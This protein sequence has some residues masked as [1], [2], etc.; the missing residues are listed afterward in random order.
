MKEKFIITL[1]QGTTSSR[2]IVFDH[3]G[4]II[5]MASREH[6]QIYPQ[7]GWVEHDP[8]E[9]WQNQKDV[10]NEAI[11][12]GG[13]SLEEILA[14]GI[15]NQRETVVLWD[16]NTGKPVYNAIV[17]QCRRTADMCGELKKDGLEE[18][19]H[20]KTGLVIDAYFSGT[21][22]RWILDN[23]PGAR[24][25]AEKGNILAGT[26]DTWLIWKLTGGKVHATDFSN[27]SRTMLFNICDLTWD[28]DILELLQIPASILPEPKSS[29]SLFGFVG[30]SVLGR[31]IPIASAVGDQQAS[32]FGQAC[33]EPG[34][35]KNTYGTGC[36]MLAN[37]GREAVFSKNKL[38]T[39]IAWGVGNRVDYALEG[40]VFI[41]GAAIQWLRDGL[42]IIQ[43][44]RQCDELAEKV[45]DTHGVYFVPAFVGMGTPY[46]DMYARG[47][48]L[49][50]TGGVT[51]EHIA[52][53]ALEAIAYQVKDLVECMKE[54]A[55]CD[56]RSLKVD[57]GASVSSIMMQFQADILDAKVIRPRVVETT[58]MGA[59]FMAGLQTGMWQN[60]GDITRIWEQERVFTPTMNTDDARRLYDGWKKAVGRSL[61]WIDR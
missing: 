6:R 18:T 22:I 8:E 21:K 19:I 7:P 9:I 45:T 38:L 60:L 50:L 25:A 5:S 59:A 32:L 24:E 33:F 54:D 57:G 30:K 11:E 29:S 52:R 20:Q 27:A 15:A 40:S 42:K 51:R 12:K 28:K 4:K 43:T 44:A 37:T 13:I 58:A 17:W 39:T 36:F 41:A 61:E 3:A 16:K 23:V 49:G 14:I 53:A 2:A 56:I 1:D 46:W 47:A 10:L 34:M 48:I 35:A 26:I 31:E 55:C